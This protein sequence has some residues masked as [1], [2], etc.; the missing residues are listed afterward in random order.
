MTSW[1]AIRSIIST[2]SLTRVTENYNNCRASR[3]QWAKR[4]KGKGTRH[5]LENFAKGKNVKG[6]IGIN[7]PPG[8]KFRAAV[9]AKLSKREARES[10]DSLRSRCFPVALH[11]ALSKV[12]EAFSLNPG[13]NF[14]WVPLRFAHNYTLRGNRVLLPNFSDL[15]ITE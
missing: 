13:G 11:Y 9:L 10:T 2:L 4:A 7:L 3:Q 12:P 5:A 15:R 14:I 1:R 6:A 8:K